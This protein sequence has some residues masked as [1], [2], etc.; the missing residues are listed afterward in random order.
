MFIKRLKISTPNQVIRDLEF[1]KGLNLIV[2]NTPMNDLTQ[3]GNNVG[4]TTVL[5]LISFCLAGNADDIYKDQENR[6]NKEQQL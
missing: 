3:T 5:K 2:D 6:K 4:K 1:K